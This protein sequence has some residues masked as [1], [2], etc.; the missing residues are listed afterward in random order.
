MPRHQE[1]G[2]QDPNANINWENESQEGS[3]LIDRL[4]QAPVD[5][6]KIYNAENNRSILGIWQLGSGGA[7]VEWED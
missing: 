1:S 4:Q 6:R 7:L 2:I 3:R 5:E